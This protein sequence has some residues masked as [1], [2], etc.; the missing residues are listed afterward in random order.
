MRKKLTVIVL[1]LAILG[2]IAV[3]GC[4]GRVTEGGLVFESV[5][6]MAS[7]K[8]YI[9]DSMWYG[10]VKDG[11]ACTVTADAPADL[12]IPDEYNGKP[13]KL[14]MT[15]IA[16]GESLRFNSFKIG[17]NVAV[18]YAFASHGVDCFEN[19]K[20]MV[21]PDSI[22]YIESSFSNCK[23]LENLVLPEGLVRIESSF[24]QLENLREFTV[25]AS[26]TYVSFSFL[27]IDDVTVNVKGNTQIT[28]CFDDSGKVSV[29]IDDESQLEPVAKYFMPDVDDIAEQSGLRIGTRELMDF[30][31]L[32]DGE[33]VLEKG[34]SHFCETLDPSKEIDPS[35][36][37][38]YVR[39]LEAPVV[40]VETCPDVKFDDYTSQDR[41]ALLEAA[42]PVYMSIANLASYAV[43]SY[44]RPD[45][46]KAPSVYIIAEKIRG[47]P[48]SYLVN[49]VG[50]NFYHMNYRFSV[51]D[52][53]TDALIC[54]FMTE[55][56]TEADRSPGTFVEGGYTFLSDHGLKSYVFVTARKY[57]GEPS[58]D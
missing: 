47:R 46:S 31:D 35:D 22:R 38:K 49:G 41:E 33:D 18:I 13:V 8:K 5:S 45:M 36:A 23:A 12:V 50:K 15:D 1:I 10:E 17:N 44:S 7:D 32:V 42:V 58:E 2:S 54:W 51:R 4:V 6:S 25:P 11:Y 14:L 20:E 39:Y 43:S 56:G 34:K 37:R 9:K 16:E 48:V 19:V 40:T 55:E 29:V 3:T 57:F 27:E 52:I 21:M 28:D 24:R 30:S 53:K 26:A